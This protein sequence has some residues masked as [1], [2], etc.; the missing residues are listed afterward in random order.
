VVKAGRN[1][2]YE[3]GT[4]SVPKRRHIKKSDAGESPKG[5]N[6]KIYFFKFNFNII[7]PFTPGLPRILFS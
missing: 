1:T 6:M 7:L 4:D 3:D 2:T 5:E